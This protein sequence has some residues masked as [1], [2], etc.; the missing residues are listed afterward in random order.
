[1][2]STQECILERDKVQCDRSSAISLVPGPWNRS[3]HLCVFFFKEGTVTCF[4]GLLSLAWSYASTHMSLRTA[5][6]NFHVG[7]SIQAVACPWKE[8]TLSAADNTR[9]WKIR[10][11]P[12]AAALGRSSPAHK[13]WPSLWAT[14][15]LG[16]EDIPALPP[17][18]SI[19]LRRTGVPVSV[20][21]RS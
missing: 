19:P 1:M 6:C 11:Y 2:F 8:Q 15:K 12:F 13:G 17:H 18:D 14:G 7:S 4:S 9:L 20:T 5:P 3:P 16:G 21:G 10:H